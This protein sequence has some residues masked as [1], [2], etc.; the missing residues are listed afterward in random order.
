MIK[1]ESKLPSNLHYQA[2]IDLLTVNFSI[3]DITKILQN[4]ERSK[5]HDH[6]KVSIHMLQ[7]CENR[8]SKPLELIFKQ[9]MKSG[10]VP[11]EQNKGN[12][13]PIH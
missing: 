1:N 4:L 11:F 13:V 3:D 5:A 6:D 9:S 8:N 12:V 2:D 7:L 10:S